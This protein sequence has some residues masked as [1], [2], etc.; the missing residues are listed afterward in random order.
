MNQDLPGQVLGSPILLAGIDEQDIGVAEC[1]GG[2]R[3][4][5]VNHGGR[6]RGSE[7]PQ[8]PTGTVKW[9]GERSDEVVR[10]S[11]I[12][13]FQGPVKGSLRDRRGRVFG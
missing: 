1:P 5:Q 6:C 4:F 3:V 11:F 10:E 7:A 8:L 13:P 9:K 12:Q 2:E